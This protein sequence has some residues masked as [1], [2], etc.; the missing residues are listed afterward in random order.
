MPRCFVEPKNLAIIR[1][2]S[3]ACGRLK[4]SDGGA[5]CDRGEGKAIINGCADGE[6]ELPLQK[7]L[8]QDGASAIGSNKVLKFDSN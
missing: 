3:A 8:H 2:A 7:Q 4:V 5:T 1:H 6:R